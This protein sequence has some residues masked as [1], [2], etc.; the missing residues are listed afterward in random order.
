M[1]DVTLK[2]PIRDGAAAQ[3]DFLGSIDEVQREQP[4]D[5]LT[6]VLEPRLTW[7]D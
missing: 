4:A 7:L 1:C 3:D 2:E 6:A 5:L